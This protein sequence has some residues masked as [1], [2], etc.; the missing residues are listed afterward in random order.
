MLTEVIMPNLGLTMEQGK[1]ISWLKQVGDTVKEGEPLFEV[2]TDKVSLEVESPISGTLL[3][4]I[5]EEGNTVPLFEVIAYIGDKTDLLPGVPAVREKAA[6]SSLALK[7][8]K[9]NGLDLSEVSGS[10]PQ[11]R[12]MKADIE[13]LLKE[14]QEPLTRQRVKASGLARKRARQFEIDLQPV[15]GSGPGG[16]IVEADVLRLVESRQ[17][18]QA[19]PD[20]QVTGF[21]VEVPNQVRRIAAERMSLSFQSAP[22]FYL[23]LEMAVTELVQLRQ[24][25]K[26]YFEY[27]LNLNLTFTDFLLKALAISLPKHPRLNASG[28]EKEIK[29]YQS[30]NLGIAIDSPQGLVVGVIHQAQQKSLEELSRRRSELTEKARTGTL[31]VEHIS[32]GTFTITNLGMFGIDDF[33]PILNPPQSAILAVGAIIERPIGIQ[34]QLVLRPTVR[35]TLAVDHRVADGA[36][37]ARFLQDLRSLLESP[38]QLLK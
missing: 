18:D 34:G 10:G 23:N 17:I 27:R 6:V 22:H 20:E 33:A 16:R 26:P 21:V 37:G 24:S 7:I 12:I 36:D 25:L 5:V 14:S 32:A 31:G 2:E 11:G 19:K 30:V 29:L 15:K 28:N 1:I 38:D 8:A 9:D 13:K 3:K 35:L 4:I